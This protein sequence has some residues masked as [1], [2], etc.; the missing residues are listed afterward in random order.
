MSFQTPISICDAISEVEKKKY[1][2]PAI[3]RGFVW[4]ED[5]IAALFDSLM[6]EYPIGSFLF[7]HVEGDNLQKYKFYEFI[8]DYHERD[9]KYVKD[10]YDLAGCSAITAI[11]DGQ[12]RLT[13]LYIGLKGTYAKKLPRKRWEN[14]EAFPR[15]EL[16]L[17]LLSKPSDSDLQYDFR[18]LTPEEAEQ[19]GQSN[20]WFKVKRI[21]DLKEEYQVNEY[22]I[23]KGLMLNPNKDSARFANQTLFKLHSVVHR[24]PSINFY[25]DDNFEMDKV[26]N[27]FVR[28]NSGGTQLSYS[29]LLLSIATAQWATVDARKEINELVEEINRI[30]EGFSF[31][32]DFILKACLVLCDIRDIAFKVGNFDRETMGV[33][34]SQWENVATRIRAAVEL[35]STFGYSRYNLASNLAVIPI[36]Y[37]LLTRDRPNTYPRSDAFRQDREVIKKWLAL[38]LLKRVF[39]GVPD[40]VLRTMREVIQD[41]SDS[42]PLDAV[43]DKFRGTNKSLIFDEDDVD[44]LFDYEY[45]QNYTF[46]TLSLL[47][48]TFDL[49]NRFH[50]DHVF[51]KSHFTPARLRRAM[52]SDNDIDFCLENYNRLANLQLLEGLP[53]QEKGSKHVDEWLDLTYPEKEHRS[54]FMTSHMIPKV[55]LSITNFREFVEERTRLMKLRFKRIVS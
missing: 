39:G 4:H 33:I 35:T 20:Y 50:V 51:P 55:N 30:P 19:N 32:K 34:E 7:W 23:E 40:A 15:K 52:V 18:F 5:Q 12:Q 41:T 47:Y 46:S 21:L 31:D 17:N 11:L 25:R 53:N 24:K 49:R 45:G 44:G 1:L 28:V 16:Y 38:A 26:L 42:F 22:L 37:Y 10:P 29:D 54:Q 48:P 9:K 2:M 36:A 13:A 43:I 6:R 27:I 14:D 3:Q 8:G